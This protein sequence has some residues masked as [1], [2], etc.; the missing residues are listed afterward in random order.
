MFEMIAP[1]E[2]R[3]D[4]RRSLCVDLDGTL[5]KSD[6]LV[7]S[8]LVLARTHPAR[9]F[10]APFYV[11]R[12]RAAFKAWVTDSVLLRI[13]HLPY[14]RKVV[15]FIR[16]QRN[17]GRSIYVATGADERLAE[18][19]AAHLGLF[20][21]VLGS[22][23]TTNLTGRKKL[24]RIRTEFGGGAYDYIGND[25]PDLPLMACAAE[26]M[27]ANP[28]LRLRLELWRRG[29]R[30]A[31]IFIDRRGALISVIR[32]LRVRRWAANLLVFLPLV[33]S[34]AAAPARVLSGFLAFCCF[35]LAA[36]STYIVE[37]LLNVEADRSD[38]KKSL[39]PFAAGD[40]SPFVGLMIGAFSLSLAFL[41]SRYLP[42][43]FFEW[44]LV[45][46]AVK[47]AHTWFFEPICFV[48]E[49]VFSGLC[50]LRLV[51]G[52]VATQSFVSNWLVGLSIFLF[53]SFAMVRRVIRVV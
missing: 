40:L 5:V 28:T 9:F 33:L 7:D 35:S 21:G 10:A 27:V 42:I 20:V 16:G 15:E 6:T 48:D 46:L 25:V 14:N 49:I 43:A 24:D 52:V 32:A 19:V 51:A 29:I 11:L 53:F 12:G 22:K 41:G 23:G 30:P 36:S 34:Q 50:T 17:L 39:R 8:L 45:Y 18:R 2:A 1:P 44:L 37:G 13:E 31:R 4:P 3:H 38:S 47:V 26:S